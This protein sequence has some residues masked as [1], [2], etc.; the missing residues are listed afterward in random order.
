MSI[1]V[2]ARAQPEYI[3]AEPYPHIVIRN[4]LG[5]ALYDQLSK[6]YPTT[7]EI[8]SKDT[9]PNK[10]IINNTRYQVSS[11]T[12]LESPLWNDFVKYHISYEFYQDAI[13]LFGD[14]I[15]SIHDIQEKYG[16]P[17][18]RLTASQRTGGGMMV[19]SVGGGFDVGLD[20]QV[21]INS[22][23]IETSSVIGVHTDQ[24]SKMFVGMLYMREDNDDSVGGDLQI[25]KHKEGH[26]PNMDIKNMELHDT[27]PYAK[28]TFVFF[29]NSPISIHAVTPRYPTQ[30]RRRLVNFIGEVYK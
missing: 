22:P 11:N 21:G 12:A 29:I 7:D 27:V 30:H 3:Q 10:T 23:V 16:K 6:E 8:L 17:I 13:K 9:G 20:C 19:E 24:P 4:A 25:V 1:S 28:N 26:T 14:H 18:E 2:L 15:E 5:E